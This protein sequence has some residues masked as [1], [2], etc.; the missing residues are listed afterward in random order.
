M[1]IVLIEKKEN[2]LDSKIWQVTPKIKFKRKL[3]IIYNT[4]KHHNV[5]ESLLKLASF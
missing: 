4:F 1:Q 3:N 2:Q 5:V